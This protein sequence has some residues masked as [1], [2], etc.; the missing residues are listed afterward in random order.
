M[1]EAMN[2]SG[3]DFGLKG[4]YDGLTASLQAGAQEICERLWQGVKTF[5]GDLPHLDDFTVVTIQRQ[6][7]I[8]QSP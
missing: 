3:E 2:K 1:S 7:I 6:G 8:G 4:I 5:T